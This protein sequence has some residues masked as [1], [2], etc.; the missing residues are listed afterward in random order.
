MFKL[1][2]KQ[3]VDA[4]L[5]EGPNTLPPRRMDL[6]ERKAFRREMARQVVRDCM[7]A[8]DVPVDAFRLRI[9][10]LDA[11]HHRFIVMLDV[12]NHFRPRRAGMDCDQATI[13]S[14]IRQSGRERFGLAIEGIY[15]RAAADR[16]ALE[17]RAH[18]RPGDTGMDQLLPHPH[19]WQLVSEEEKQALIEAIRQGCDMPPLHVGDLEYRSEV[20]PL[21]PRARS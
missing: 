10:P 21:D 3:S 13:E 19:P 7:E 8:L 14:D 2:R 12:G 18:A 15:W 9:M 6:E 4:S 1:S 16:P 20:A 17:R 5:A 11:R